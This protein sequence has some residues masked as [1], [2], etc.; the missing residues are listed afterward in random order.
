[1]RYTKKFHDLKIGRNFMV[2]CDWFRKTDQL[3]IYTIKDFPLEKKEKGYFVRDNNA[4]GLTGEL[5]STPCFFDFDQDVYCF[6]CGH[7]VEWGAVREY[8][9]SRKI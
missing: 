6:D 2:N 8:E 5:K 9:A 7:A 4:H 1:M 3:K